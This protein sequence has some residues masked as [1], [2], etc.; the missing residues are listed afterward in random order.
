[1]KLLS[2]EERLKEKQIV[3]AEEELTNLIKQNPEIIK[4]QV[5]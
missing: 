4:D 3:A 2:I 5:N 1:M